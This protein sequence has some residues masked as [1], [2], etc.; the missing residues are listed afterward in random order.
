MFRIQESKALT[1]AN[2]LIRLQSQRNTNGAQNLLSSNTKYSL[3]KKN[4][5]SPQHGPSFPLK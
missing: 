1:S 5:P 4:P 3:K 2:S